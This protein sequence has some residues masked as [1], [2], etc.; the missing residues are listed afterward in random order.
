M[1]CLT[2][3]N[4]VNKP[5]L[6]K[7]IQCRKISR[8]VPPWCF[9][10]GSLN[11]DESPK[12]ILWENPEPSPGSGT[13]S[14][15][16][17]TSPAR[18][19]LAHPELAVRIA[20]QGRWSGLFSGEG[21]CLLWSCPQ[22]CWSPPPSLS[23][24]DTWRSV[25]GLIVFFSMM[26]SYLCGCFCGFTNYWCVAVENILCPW[27][28]FV[29]SFGHRVPL[30]MFGLTACCFCKMFFCIIW[31]NFS[32]LVPFWVVSVPLCGCCVVVVSEWS[33]LK[34]KWAESRPWQLPVSVGVV[35]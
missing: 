26:G 3:K 1:C 29:S 30:K 13:S 32:G 9:N 28:Y 5:N 6:K 31:S 2:I 34:W 16:T 12:L 24:R 14:G 15:E 18:P 8:V 35:H 7:K 11:L 21:T 23:D 4:H 25:T 10:E 19:G 17:R 27:L 22:W 33:L 20:L